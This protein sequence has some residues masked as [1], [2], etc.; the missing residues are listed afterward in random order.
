MEY[1]DWT[2]LITFYSSNCHVNAL[3]LHGDLLVIPSFHAKLMLVLQKPVVMA[4][5]S[6]ILKSWRWHKLVGNSWT[7][8]MKLVLCL[9]GQKSQALAHV[10]AIYFMYQRLTLIDIGLMFFKSIGTWFLQNI[11]G[12]K[13]F[14]IILYWPE[15]VS[16]L[17]IYFW[18]IIFINCN[19]ISDLDTTGCLYQIQCYNTSSVCL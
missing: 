12:K 9:G 10:E 11:N 7:K 4:A 3:W 16:F 13:S 19:L 5:H 15:W 8:S 1:D 14:I 6:H 18:I 2:E 17:S